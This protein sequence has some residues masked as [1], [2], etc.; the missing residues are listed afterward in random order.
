LFRYFLAVSIL[1]LTS[2]C[3]AGE[4]SEWVTVQRIN[5]HPTWGVK[6]ETL[7]VV[8][9][10]CG[11]KAVEWSNSSNEV[12]MNRVVSSMLAAR[13]SKAKVRFWISTCENGLAQVNQTQI[14]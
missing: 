9:Q 10:N 11:V 13:F 4:W 2:V 7:E 12:F 1:L 5:L 8:S 6:V 14:Q 3:N